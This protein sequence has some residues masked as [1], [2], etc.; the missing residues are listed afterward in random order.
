MRRSSKRRLAEFK[1]KTEPLA[2]I[3]RKSDGL[4]RSTGIEIGRSF[5]D[6]ST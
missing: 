4:H 3:L 2:L 5:A 6:I 1:A